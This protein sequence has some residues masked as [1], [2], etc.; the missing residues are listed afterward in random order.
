MLPRKCFILWYNTHYDTIRIILRTHFSVLS[1]LEQSLN[2][3]TNFF[4][5][6]LFEK[7]ISVVRLFDTFIYCSGNSRCQQIRMTRY[8]SNLIL[9]ISIYLSIYLWILSFFLYFF[10]YFSFPFSVILVPAVPTLSLLSDKSDHKRTTRGFCPIRICG[11][12]CDPSTSLSPFNR[13]KS[14]VVGEQFKHL[15]K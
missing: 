12:T 6:H 10:S 14:Q 9:F 2:L 5:T 4:S 3:V 15:Y 1:Y 11:Q 7:F 13:W 8:K